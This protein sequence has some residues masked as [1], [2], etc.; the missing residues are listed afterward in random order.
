CSSDLVV[1]ERKNGL[2]QLRI[3][4]IRSGDEHYIDFGE[5]AYTA[6]VGSNPEFNTSI[7]RFSYTSLVTPHSTYD[8]NMDTREKKLM[9]QQEVVGGYEV[10]A[11]VTERL[12]V[13][14]RDGSEI[15]VS[16]VY[17]RG[18]VKDGKAPL[19]LYGY[20]SYGNSMNATF[21]SN[22]LS[23]L[24]RGFAFAIAH[25]RGGQEMGRQ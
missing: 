15:P 18:F 24:N 12:Y 22:R 20:G 4:S 11:Y 19:L 7:L 2:I 1:T 8:Y 25:I 16:I 14:A 10:K 13:T 9:K 3:R 5:P 6:A 17:K 23:L 21:S